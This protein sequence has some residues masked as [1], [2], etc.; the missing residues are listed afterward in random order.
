[1]KNRQR[2]TQN[3]TLIRYLKSLYDKMLAAFVEHSR[4][5]A[6]LRAEYPYVSELFDDLVESDVEC[7]RCIGELL[8]YLGAES[9]FDIRINGGTYRSD[10]ISRIISA[11]LERLRKSRSG[12]ER[13]YS[14]TDDPMVCDGADKMR[15]SAL[16]NIRAFERMTLS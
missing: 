3:V 1:M 4:Y 15:E 2:D 12:I 6:A 14:L 10:E 11:E 5:A 9:R 7:C 13:I 16:E 8:T